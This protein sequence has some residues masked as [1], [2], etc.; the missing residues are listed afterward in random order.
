MI[1]PVNIN[2]LI[3]NLLNLYIL[4]YIKT[5]VSLKVVQLIPIEW[6]F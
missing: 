6:K 5:I 2:W 1:P 3:Q 4:H